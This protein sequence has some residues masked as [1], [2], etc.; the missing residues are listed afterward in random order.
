MFENLIKEAVT[1]G[2]KIPPAT[3][4]K[5][6]REVSNHMTPN[7]FD[8]I[9]ATLDDIDNILQKY[10][11]MLVDVDGSA[12]EAIFLGEDGS[13]TIHIGDMDG[14]FTQVMLSVSWHKME[15]SRKWELVIYVT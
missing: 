6:R 15:R 4:K 7:Y 10:G 12:F 13:T 2:V 11:Y 3:L 9:G 1:K 8:S 5:M 14:N